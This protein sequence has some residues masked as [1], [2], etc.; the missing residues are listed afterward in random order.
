[1]KKQSKQK[2]QASKHTHRLT[3]GQAR[4]AGS[5]IDRRIVRQ[6]DRQTSS[7][8]E[9]CRDISVAMTT[10]WSDCCRLPYGNVHWAKPRA[11]L[12]CSCTV[13]HEHEFGGRHPLTQF[14]DSVAWPKRISFSVAPPFSSPQQPL[15]LFL[16][17]GKHTLRSS[18]WPWFCTPLA[19]TWVRAGRAAAN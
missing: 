4:E 6:L 7:S 3:E 15:F 8:I 5:Q 1:M 12:N 16:T 17:V 11:G 2:P 10:I 19:S 13:Q 9:R 18:L 14:R